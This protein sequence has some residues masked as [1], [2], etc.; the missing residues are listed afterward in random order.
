MMV[1]T[2]TALGELSFNFKVI[3]M[4]FDYLFSIDLKPMLELSFMPIELAL[5]RQKSF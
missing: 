4:V 3:D 2:R 1:V 5:D